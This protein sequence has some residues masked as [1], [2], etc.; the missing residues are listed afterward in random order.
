MK[1]KKRLS[2]LVVA[3]VLGMGFLFS[4]EV[5]SMERGENFFSHMQGQYFSSEDHRQM[6]EQ[7]HGEGSFED[8]KRY[9]E[10]NR[11]VSKS[12]RSNHRSGMMRNRRNSMPCHDVSNR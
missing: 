3:A 12:Y 2:L 1:K 5:S 10:E 8:M 11:G 7:M 6:H 4:K 9:M